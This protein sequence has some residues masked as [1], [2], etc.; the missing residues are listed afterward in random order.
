MLFFCSRTVQTDEKLKV[1]LRAGVEEGGGVNGCLAQEC[2]VIG[3]QVS[4]QFQSDGKCGQGLNLAV[5]YNV[6]RQVILK[7]NLVR[8]SEDGNL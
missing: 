6:N 7:G 2:D 4:M 3:E 5:V 8:L 1:Q